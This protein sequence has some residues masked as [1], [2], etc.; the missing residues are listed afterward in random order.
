[1]YVPYYTAIALCFPIQRS[2]RTFINP[3]YIY[4][5]ALSKA[6]AIAFLKFNQQDDGDHTFKLQNDRSFINPTYIYLIALSK[7]KA[8][9]VLKFNPQKNGDRTTKS[10]LVLIYGETHLILV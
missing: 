8:I 6:K 2:D 5:I 10:A 9:A 1:M 7:S 3:T 4:L